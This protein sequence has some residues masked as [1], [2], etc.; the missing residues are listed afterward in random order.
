M[1]R[2][3]GVATGLIGLALL[4]GPGGASAQPVAKGTL[5]NP[6]GKAVTG[7]VVLQAW[8]LEAPVG[9]TVRN[10]IVAR[11]STDQ[12]GRFT[13][14]AR[15]TR[16]LRRMALSNSQRR[17]DFTVR[18]VGAGRVAEYTVSRFLTKDGRLVAAGAE[19]L[20]SASK[21]SGDRVP[22]KL[23]ERLKPQAR[24]SSPARIADEC[25]SNDTSEGK[26]IAQTVIG[27][28]NNAYRDTK[29]WWA[30]GL[31]GTSEFSVGVI[32][33]DDISLDGS[34]SVKN[35][36]GSTVEAGP[37]GLYS[38]RQYSEFQFEK[39]RK[40]SGCTG[41]VKHEVRAI[42][43]LG[44]GTSKKQRGAIRVCSKTD[45]LKTAIHEGGRGYRRDRE[46]ATEWEGGAN[47]YGIGLNV[48]SGYSKAVRAKWKFG[49]PRKRLH[50]LCGDDGPPTEAGRIFS[51]LA[52]SG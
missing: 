39:T 7:A 44:D 34:V 10:P 35:A 37:V 33:G 22:L 11:T 5:T 26:K 47:V 45:R 49:G 12:A 6:A 14:D 40:S 19:S 43:W 20:A 9:K 32:S 1:K 46:D 42:K 38:R 15:V 52:R 4:I 24:A 50:Y 18:G 51:G 25:T 21:A 3:I 29:A 17:I 31:N 2:F 27:E 23:D 28:L 13:L 36:D 48:K 8:P 30:Y 41:V 16:K